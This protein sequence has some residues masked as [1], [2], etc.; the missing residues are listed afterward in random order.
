MNFTALLDKNYIPR[1]NTLLYS[2][3]KHDSKFTFY[4]VALDNET[5]H[6]FKN[7]ENCISI[8]IQEIHEFYPELD[9]IEKERDRVSYIFTLSPYY[10]SFILEKFSNVNHI[11]SLDSDQ[12]FFSS[13]KVIFDL[14][15]QYSVLLTPHRFSNKLK[16]LNFERFGKFNVSFQIFKRDEIGL[17]CLKLWREQCLEWCYDSEESEKYADQK[18]LD[19][20]SVEF[21][22]TVCEISNIGLGLAPWN[23]EDVIISRKEGKVFVNDEPLILFHYQGLKVL[24]FGFFYTFLDHYSLK[25]PKNINKLIYKPI[26]Q[27]LIKFTV[28]IDSFSRN[29]RTFDYDFMVEKADFVFKRKFGKIFQ[30]NNYLKLQRLKNGLFD[31]FTNIFR[32]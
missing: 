12:F 11:C 5:Y 16:A 25:F 8:S 28:A 19:Y 7:K 17:K 23:V 3:F 4:V 2:L 30:Y 26:V 14:L 18:Y 6:H 29:N 31:R 24:E 22:D 32:R 21:G 10:P 9:K 27:S 1:L 20:W 13:P 15:E